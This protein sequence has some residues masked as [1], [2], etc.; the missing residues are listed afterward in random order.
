[1]NLAL[2]P[3][4]VEQPLL[5]R[6]YPTAARAQP[7]QSIL[8]RSTA[9]G[10]HRGRRTLVKLR[11]QITLALVLAL[12]AVAVPGA[13]AD[14]ISRYLA[15]HSQ[16]N[17]TRPDDRSG[18]RSNGSPAAE[19]DAIDRYLA[20]HPR[21]SLSRP[22]DR[23]GTRNIDSPAAESDAIDRYLAN[24]LQSVPTRPD[25]RSGLRVLATNTTSPVAVR[26]SA[27]S[28]AWWDAAVGAAAALALMLTL[29]AAARLRRPHVAL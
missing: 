14:A 27:H 21:A 4:K 28:F 26:S 5:P 1:M 13:Q 11:T 7:A 2:A 9:T 25:D 23:S 19:P 17:I 16:A 20:N 6:R 22:D 3:A 12:G 8:E 29:A 24:H 15:N 10:G 18:T